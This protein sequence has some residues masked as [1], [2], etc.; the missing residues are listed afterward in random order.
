ML[1]RN[2]NQMT[3]TFDEKCSIC[4][5]RTMVDWAAIGLRAGDEPT[6]MYQEEKSILC[7]NCCKNKNFHH[8]SCY[9]CSEY[10]ICFNS[11]DS[12]FKDFIAKLKGI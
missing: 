6:S 5:A 10:Q 4:G 11:F 1:K 8:D 12:V 7:T 3:K 9:T 2:L